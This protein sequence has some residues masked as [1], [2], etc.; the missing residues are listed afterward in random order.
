MAAAG[1][2]GDYYEINFFGYT[3]TP[4]VSADLCLIVVEPIVAVRLA[5]D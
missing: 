3:F 4:K 5:D 2:Y 1:K